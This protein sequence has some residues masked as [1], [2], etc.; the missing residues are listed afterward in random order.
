[1]AR[2]AVVGAGIAGLGAAYSLQKASHQV[3]IFEREDRV[4]G[5]MLTRAEN[6]FTWEPGAQFMLSGYTQM[7]ALMAEL[8]VETASTAI[9]STSASLLPNGK[10]HYQRVDSP[11]AALSHPSLSFG[12]KLRMGKVLMEAMKHKSQIEDFHHPERAAPLDTESLRAWGDREI[13]KDAVDF[14]LSVPTSTFFFWRPE[15]TPWWIP[16]SFVHML[17]QSQVIVPAGGMGAVPAALAAQLD[18]RLS[19][20]VHRIDANDDSTATLRLD[21]G[22]FTADRVIVA[23]P[24]PAALALLPDPD[25]A[26]G[27]ARA[28]Y[29]RGARYVRNVTTAIAYRAAPE[30]RAYG[31]GFPSVLGRHLA[32]IGWDHLKGPDRAPAGA[33][34]AVVM[35]TNA[36]S[37]ELWDKD[38]ATVEDDLLAAVNGVYPGSRNGAIFIRVTRWEH[39]MPLMPPGRARELAAALSAGPI[40]NSPIFTCGDYWMGPCTEQALATGQNA[41][42]EAM[43]SII[44]T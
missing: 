21:N 13:G 7:R 34:L 42:A 5:R 16:I 26:L 4:G 29:L 37:I 3:T 43:R 17:S 2:I 31:V 28:N 8:G 41:A 25:T 38:D 14:V 24:A 39:A 11:T 19:T 33:G 18:V 12:T 40:L 44:T 1:M 32:A 23:T 10:L 9:P 35:P 15:E 27:P 30:Q 6:G 22:D 20:P 36:H